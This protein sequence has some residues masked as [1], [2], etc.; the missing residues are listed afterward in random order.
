MHIEKKKRNGETR[1]KDT[2][3]M[4]VNGAMGMADRI[5]VV[6]TPENPLIAPKDVKPSFPGWEVIGVFNAGVIE[7]E[8]EVLMLMRVAE[9]PLQTDPDHVLVPVLDPAALARGESTVTTVRV[10]RHDPALD[11]SDPRVV[12]ER[13]GKTIWLTS[14]SHLRLARSRDGVRFTIDEKPTIMP[15]GELESWGI[16]DPRITRIGDRYYIT[17]SAVSGAGVAVGLISTADFAGFRREGIILAPTNK[18]V[19]LFPE[20]IGGKFWMLHRP[21]PEG[22]GSPEIWTAC[23][24]DLL[25]WGGHRRLLDVRENS[26]E[27]GRIGAGAVPIRT[28]DGWLILYHGA[29]KDQRYCM[30]AA[31]LDLEDPGRVLARLDEPLLVPEAEYETCGF[32]S[33]VVFACGAIVRDGRVILYYGASD[34]TMASASFELEPLLDRLKH[35]NAIRQ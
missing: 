7:H 15:E 6:R 1:F 19:V 9:R 28:D 23:S 24:P 11:F 26:W 31:L 32:F 5:P 14:L 13:S 20:S 16:E 2:K 29:D 25:H 33:H 4:G 34:S 18:D 27:S 30:G 35:R 17:Y 21:V 12:R 3:R 22:I 8:G 10:N